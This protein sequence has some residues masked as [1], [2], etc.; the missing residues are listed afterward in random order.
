MDLTLSVWLIG[1][2]AAIYTAYGGLKSVAWA[3]LFLGSALIG[4]GFFVLHAGLQAVGGFDTTPAPS[5][6]IIGIAIVAVVAALY[7]I[8]W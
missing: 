5:V 8:F 6:K 4:G 2:V 3:D 1:I 7:C